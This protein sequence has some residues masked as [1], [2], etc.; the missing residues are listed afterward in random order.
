MSHEELI[1]A[2]KYMTDI[3]DSH[4]FNF[5]FD[6]SEWRKTYIE[7]INEIV[8]RDNNASNN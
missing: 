2:L 3:P 8:K 5:N 7:L 4:Y 6:S 1:D